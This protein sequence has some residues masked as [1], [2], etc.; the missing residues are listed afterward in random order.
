MFDRNGRLD[1]VLANHQQEKGCEQATEDAGYDRPG[2]YRR[3]CEPRRLDGET[4][5]ERGDDAQ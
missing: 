2:D 1:A 5:T 3:R 4:G